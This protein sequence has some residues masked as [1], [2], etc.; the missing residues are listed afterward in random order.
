MQ[1]RCHNVMENADVHTSL[2]EHILALNGAVREV[3]TNTGR[4][5]ISRSRGGF[6]PRSSP[7]QVRLSAEAISRKQY[8]SQ[9]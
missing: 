2:R 1:Q 8:N 5:W 9:A 7:R 6:Q 4:W 3:A